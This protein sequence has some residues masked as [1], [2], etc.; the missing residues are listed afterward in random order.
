M[1]LAWKGGGCPNPNANN[2][3]APANRTRMLVHGWCLQIEVYKL[4]A[5]VPLSVQP[6]LPQVPFM[7]LWQTA[8]F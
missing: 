2:T 1:G 5:C 4:R 3:T 6:A 7:A 8:I